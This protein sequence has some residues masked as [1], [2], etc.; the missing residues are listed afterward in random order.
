MARE[1]RGAGALTPPN[2]IFAGGPFGAGFAALFFAVPVGEVVAGFV[3]VLTAGL[4][5]SAETA[6]QISSRIRPS[7]SLR[8]NPRPVSPHRVGRNY[9]KKWRQLEH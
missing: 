2:S 4:I 9:H 7:A 6:P 5:C 1:A 3:A 8:M